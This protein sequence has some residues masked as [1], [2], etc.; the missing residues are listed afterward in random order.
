MDSEGRV[1]ITTDRLVLRELEEA[2][3]E[4]IA[5]YTS[6]PEVTREMLPGQGTPEAARRLV[7][8]AAAHVGHRHRFYFALG[9]VLNGDLI[10]TC[11][12]DNCGPGGDASIGWDL[13]RRYWGQGIMTEAVRAI[14]NFAFNLVDVHSVQAECFSTN[15][16]SIRVMVKSG[17]MRQKL[18]W[19]DQH[20]LARSYGVRRSFLRYAVYKED[21][22]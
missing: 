4:I 17:M 12:L 22:K 19:T 13:D 2:D 20:R 8:C 21:G 18:G 7:Q 9:I 6:D 5:A 14:V 11:V 10:G 3:W 16:A 15:V 1:R